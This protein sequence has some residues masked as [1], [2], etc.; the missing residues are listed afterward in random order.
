VQVELQRFPV[1]QS[2]FFAYA[3]I[4][5]NPSF[6]SNNFLTYI[7]NQTTPTIVP[8]TARNAIRLVTNEPNAVEI[9]VVLIIINYRKYGIT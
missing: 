1:L 9:S 8:I 3:E 6:L 7:T 4:P 2:E 5:C